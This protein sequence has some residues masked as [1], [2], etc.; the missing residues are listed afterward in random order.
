[1]S[2]DK[3]GARVAEDTEALDPAAV[4]AYLRDHPGFFRKRPDL[5]ADLQLPHGGEGAVSLVERQVAL[6]RERNIDMRKR[7][8]LMGE[9]AERNEALFTATRAL[10]LGLLETPSAD[11]IES[12]YRETMRDTYRVQMSNL[13]WMP[14]AAERVDGIVPV[15]DATGDMLSGLVKHG[16][17]L[18][19]V[20][21]GEEMGALFG[22][23]TVEGSAAVAPLADGDTLLG[24]IAVGDRDMTRYQATD[25]TLF[26]DYLAEV[27]VRLLPRGDASEP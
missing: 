21:R 5:L 10:V 9:R 12:V 6:L 13:V 2:S 1:M 20:L 24:I 3:V 26:L 23:G 27:I 22:T 7:L 17:S 15:A 25:G 4:E 8:A 11:A 18:C 16:K 14:A 19:G